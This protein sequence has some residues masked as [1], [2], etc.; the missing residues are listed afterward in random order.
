[1]VGDAR[2]A[3]VALLPRWGVFLFETAIVDDV[4]VPSLPP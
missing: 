4:G 2:S 1:M 3:P